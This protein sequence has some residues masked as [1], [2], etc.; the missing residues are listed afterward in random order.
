MF[1]PLVKNSPRKIYCSGRSDRVA[2]A[3]A[4]ITDIFYVSSQRETP[5]KKFPGEIYG[6]EGELPRGV[7]QRDILVG[8]LLLLL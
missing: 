5:V 2:A 3:P 6:W 4:A 8:N 7:H 1:I